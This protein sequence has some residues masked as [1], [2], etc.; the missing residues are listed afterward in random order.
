[1]PP[2]LGLERMALGFDL[3]WR[4]DLWYARLPHSP[5]NEGKV[6]RLVTRPGPGQRHCPSVVELSPERGVHGDRW[7]KERERTVD[8]QISLINVHVIDALALGDAERAALAGD[9]L[10]VDLDLSEE[11]LP[12]GAL[13]RIGGALL[14]VSPM[15]HRPCRHFV[16]R[17]GAQGAKKVARANRRGRRGRGLLC[18]IVRG[19]EIRLGDTIYVESRPLTQTATMEPRPN[20]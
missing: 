9:N 16:A 1:M 19:G 17:F 2:R 13:L 15:P 14:E 7:E 8:N 4:F 10:H 20:P 3:S 11:N 12:V 18:R 5:S 6:R